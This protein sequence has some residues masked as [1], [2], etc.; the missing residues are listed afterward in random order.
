[1]ALVTNIPLTSANVEPLSRHE[2]LT[3]VN[4]CLASEFAK[5]EQI[6]FPG[7]LQL[8]KVKFNS[9]LELDWLSNWKIVQTS[10]KQLGIEKVIPVEKLIK[11]KFQDNFEFLQWFKKFFDANYD[12]HQYDPVEM[13]NYEE[14]PK[15]GKINKATANST[16]LKMPQRTTTTQLKSRQPSAASNTVPMGTR[17]VGSDASINSGS[18]GSGGGGASSAGRKTTTAAGRHPATMALPKQSSARP[19]TAQHRAKAAAAASSPA[20]ASPRHQQQQPPSPDPQLIE[21][22]KQKNTEIDELRNQLA[23]SDE[24]ISGL[25]RERDFYFAKLRKIEVHCQDSEN[26]GSL[27]VASV[28]QILYETEEGFAPPTDDGTNGTSNDEGGDIGTQ[29]K[30]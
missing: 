29:L 17:R 28:L 19:A 22:L 20:V 21:E 16:A 10:W 12:G 11:G 5:L 18:G 4:Q 27:E 2:M 24:V 8:K 26:V 25:E 9:R 23:E 14:L 7:S 13:R 30:D 15:D 3:W 6:L 1:M